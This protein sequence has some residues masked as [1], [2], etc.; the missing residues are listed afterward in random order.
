GGFTAGETMV[1]SGFGINSNDVDSVFRAGLMALDSFST[2]GITAKYNGTGSNTCSGDSGGPLLM[3][4]DGEWKLV[5]ATS[6][7][8]LQKCGPGDTSNFVNL[9]D[10][11]VKSFITGQT[12]ISY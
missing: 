2:V 4:R 3:S 11:S 7:G 10:P 8:L 9:S 1:I 5:G 6:N 12:G